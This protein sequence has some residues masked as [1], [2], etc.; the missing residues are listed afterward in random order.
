MRVNSIVFSGQVFSVSEERSYGK[1]GKIRDIRMSQSRKK[2][3]EWE[4]EWIT[5]TTFDKTADIC[6]G[7]QKGD[8][9]VVQGELKYDEW[10][11]KS[12]NKRSQ[13]KITAKLV[14][15]YVKPEYT[16][17][18]DSPPEVDYSDPNNVPF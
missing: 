5:V 9:V 14:H 1:G 15:K 2:G 6:A 17:S 8:R 13:H 4:N 18:G 16:T 11:D 10:T 12:G 3:D 7:L